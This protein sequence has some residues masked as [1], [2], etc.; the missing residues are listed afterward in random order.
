MNKLIW[1]EV[2]LLAL[3]VFFVITTKGLCRKLE[4]LTELHISGY[5]AH[6]VHTNACIEVRK[7]V[8]EPNVLDPEVPVGERFQ[9]TYTD[10]C[11][12]E[13]T[14]KTLEIITL[15]RYDGGADRDV[16]Y[17]RINECGCVP[18]SDLSISG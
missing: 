11:C 3:T 17:F 5:K 13:I 14:S 6:V 16:L 8:I 7:S 4:K 18:C 10:D 9:R 2:S 15:E 12:C 1:C